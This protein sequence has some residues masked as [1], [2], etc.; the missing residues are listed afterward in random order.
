MLIEAMLRIF[1]RETTASLPH[2]KLLDKKK[3]QKKQLSIVG[4][5]NLEVRVLF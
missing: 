3:K 5:K 2:R 1:R 4:I